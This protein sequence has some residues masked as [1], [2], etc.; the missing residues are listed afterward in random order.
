MVKLIDLIEFS[1]R[2][3]GF[4]NLN[5]QIFSYVKLILDH[6]FGFNEKDLLISREIVINDIYKIRK[7]KSY[8]LKLKKG[9]PVQ[10]ILKKS[11]FYKNEFFV[12]EN[13]LI[14][15]NETEIL[16]DYCINKIKKGDEILEIGVGSGVISISIA[17]EKSVF[18]DATDISSSA[19]YVARKNVKR[20]NP[21]NRIRIFH[22]DLF[23]RFKKKYDFIISNP[24]YI[25]SDELKSLRENGLA[26][27]E[28]SLDGGKSGLIII[29]KIILNA[30]DY[31]KKNGK[32]IF[33]I[34]YNQKDEVENLLKEN[35]FKSIRFLKDFNNIDRIAVGMK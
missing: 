1:K 18:I 21:E 32:L 25:D 16:V 8:I 7:F 28:I 26:D 29:R 11:F 4:E 19:I 34:G 2:E 30:K 27:P 9:I 20:F 3:L 35:G 31:L 10:Y 14:P 17:L 5:N 13:V 15:R 23:P 6:V 22:S 33:E 24:P 12:N